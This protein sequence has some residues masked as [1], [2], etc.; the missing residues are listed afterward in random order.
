MRISRLAT[1]F[2][3]AAQVAVGLGAQYVT[4]SV[5]DAGLSVSVSRRRSGS[6]GISHGRAYATRQCEG[7]LDRHGD[8]YRRRGLGM[9]DRELRVD[10]V[11]IP[12]RIDDSCRCHCACRTLAAAGPW[13]T[14]SPRWKRCCAKRSKRTSFR[15]RSLRLAPA[16]TCCSRPPPARIR[17]TLSRNWPPP[18]TIFDLASLTKVMSTATLAM[19]AVDENRIR[20]DDPVSAG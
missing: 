1:I 12:R 17:S 4:R 16:P 14:D 19:R 20:L 5:L 18:H 15:A 13:M 8:R 6:G 2:W 10:L 3:G 7:D 11:L 9:V